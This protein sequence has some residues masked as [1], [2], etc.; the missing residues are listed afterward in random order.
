M[1]HYFPQLSIPYCKPDLWRYDTTSGRLWNTLLAICLDPPESPGLQAI[2]SR[3]W[4]E[5]S[6]H[7][8]VQGTL[9]LFSPHLDVL[10]PRRGRIVLACTVC[11]RCASYISRSGWSSRLS[12]CVL[13]YY[14][15]Y[16]FSTID[17]MWE[18]NVTWSCADLIQ[19]TGG[20]AKH[21]SVEPR[22]LP[23]LL[24]MFRL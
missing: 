10:V 21:N 7:L 3:H 6:C 14:F 12:V 20:C 4:C 13:P 11:Y 23:I 19:V 15:D 24:V 16:P 8:L 18:D 22:N 1:Y 17:W 2:Y 5:A 9:K